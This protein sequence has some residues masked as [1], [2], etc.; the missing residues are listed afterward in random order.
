[1]KNIY[2]IIIVCVIFSFSCGKSKK[3]IVVNNTLSFLN[4]KMDSIGVSSIFHNFEY[5]TLETNDES[6]MGEISKIIFYENKYYLL[7][8]SKGKKIYVFD[9]K[10]NFIRSIGKKG[11]G[12]GEYSNLE[13]FT[14]NENTGQI[15]LLGFPSIVYVYDRQGQ[16]INQKKL[17]KQALLWNICWHDRGYF[18][19][20]NHQSVLEGDEAYLIFDYDNDFNLQSSSIDVLPDYVTI[21]SF[22]TNPFLKNNDRVSYFDVFRSQIHYNIND[23]EKME[24]YNI[25]LDGKE[26]PLKLYANTQLFF[27]KQ[28][29]YRFF[30]DAIIENGILYMYFSNCGG[31]GI[32]II[33]IITGK[34][35]SYGMNTWFPYR[36]LGYA[37]DYFYTSVEPNTL[38]Q[39]VNVN[40]SDSIN[41]HPLTDDANPVIVKFK[42][43]NIFK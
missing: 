3:N 11:N 40:F 20:S 27:T 9:D 38:K 37:N 13:D 19:S 7:D 6:I 17:T 31:S 4:A 23:A 8:R 2:L 32:S 14:I 24:C 16:F 10:G 39:Y 26:V 1:M 25:D 12:P 28:S 33:D 35:L 5:I 15:I 18:L 41:M 43:K 34:S 30:M 21:P 36:F 22:L 29:E 42:S